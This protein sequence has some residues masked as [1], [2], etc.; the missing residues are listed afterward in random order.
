MTEEELAKRLFR[1]NLI[2]QIDEL[3]EE[4]YIPHVTNEKAIERLHVDLVKGIE[5]VE[6]GVK[7]LKKEADWLRFIVRYGKDDESNILRSAARIR[8]AK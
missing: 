6:V 2:R 8:E 7:K 1:D 3:F 4:G 5:K